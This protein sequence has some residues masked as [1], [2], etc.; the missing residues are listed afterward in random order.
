MPWPHRQIWSVQTRLPVR[1]KSF[2]TCQGIRPQ[3][4]ERS[5]ASKYTLDAGL[6]PP[7]D[8][9]SWLFSSLCLLF[10]LRKKRTAK[11]TYTMPSSLP[12]PQL[13]TLNL[14]CQ[15]HG[16]PTSMSVPNL[17]KDILAARERELK[18]GLGREQGETAWFT[19]FWSFSPGS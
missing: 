3:G 18:P 6:Q 16:K 14:S 9:H 15:A 1:Q 11:L 13:Q 12:T 2:L 19:H 10:S 4:V 17:Q 8:L 5:E 7:P